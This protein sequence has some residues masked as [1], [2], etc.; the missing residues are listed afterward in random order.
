MD[1]QSTS[2]PLARPWGTGR[3]SPLSARAWASHGGAPCEWTAG[4]SSPAAGPLQTPH[5]VLSPCTIISV[6][7]HPRTKDPDCIKIDG[8]RIVACHDYGTGRDRVVPGMRARRGVPSVPRGAGAQ[9]GG[10]SGGSTRSFS[11]S[12]SSR[13]G[14]CWRPSCSTGIWS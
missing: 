11:D 5:C 7:L 2:A 12:S 13:S 6:H 9:R 1:M 14:L 4:G 10:S 8:A 3:G